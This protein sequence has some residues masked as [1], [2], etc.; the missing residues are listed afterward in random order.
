MAVFFTEG[1]EDSTGNSVLGHPPFLFRQYYFLSRG[2]MANAGEKGKCS[3]HGA[4]P[5]EQ[6]RTAEKRTPS[7]AGLAS[8]LREVALA[9]GEAVGLQ[10]LEGRPASSLCQRLTEPSCP[11]P[12]STPAG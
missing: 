11:V 8:A 12:G 4:Q 9:S 5:R 3:P 6:L 1:F 2:Q 7:A 10:E